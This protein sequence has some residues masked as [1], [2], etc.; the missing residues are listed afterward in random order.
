MLI[1]AMVIAPL[2]GPNL[3]LALGT[4]LGDSR[5]MLH[6][7]RT[8]LAGLG[9]ALLVSVFIGMLWSVNLESAELLA[10]TDV[11]MESVALALASG[12]AAVLLYG[13]LLGRR[14]SRFSTRN[15]ATGTGNGLGVWP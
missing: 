15:P 6:S 2:L 9:L 14:A 13:C 12:A 11:G 1:G 10:R 5:L 4:A 7:L 3:A 8:N